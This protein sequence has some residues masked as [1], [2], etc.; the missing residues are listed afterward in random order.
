MNEQQFAADTLLERGLPLPVRATLF[1]RLLGFKTLKCYQPTLGNLIRINR[2]Y[3]KTG[4][5]AETFKEISLRDAQILT[6]NHGFRLCK[7]IALGMVKGW[8]AP[9]LLANLIA[10][11]LLYLLKPKQICAVAQVMVEYSGTD[12][13][14]DTTSYISKLSVLNRKLGQKVQGS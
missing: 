11:R 7:I 12:V 14:I 5:T 1:F 10:F 9:I 3:L 4:I 2:I 6:V 13:F 8:I